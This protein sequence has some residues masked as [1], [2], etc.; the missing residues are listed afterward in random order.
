MQCYFLRLWGT[1]IS[2]TILK[3]S[4]LDEDQKQAVVQ[5]VTDLELIVDPQFRRLKASVDMQQ[6]LHLFNVNQ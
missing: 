6:A 4:S 5:N 1:G 2:D 3:L